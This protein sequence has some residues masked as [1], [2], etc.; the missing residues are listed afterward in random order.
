MLRSH[1]RCPPAVHPSPSAAPRS[2]WRRAALTRQPRSRR[3]RQQQQQQRR[4][5]QGPAA[6]RA[7]V[8]AAS[9]PLAAARPRRLRIPPRRGGRERLPA[10]ECVELCRVPVPN[11]YRFALAKPLSSLQRRAL[12]R[13]TFFIPPHPPPWHN[14]FLPQDTA[15][16]PAG[17]VAALIRAAALGSG[18]PSAKGG[19]A[20]EK[21]IYDYWERGKHGG[22]VVPCAAWGCVHPA[23]TPCLLGDFSPLL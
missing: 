5:P 9:A 13:K 1:P 17:R 19:H 12:A 10:A 6:P 20:E 11:P 3:Q 21:V 18:R 16:A 4:R 22:K 7:H 15:S 8:P 2:L 23:G 14:P